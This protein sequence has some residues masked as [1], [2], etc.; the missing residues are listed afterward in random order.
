[1]VIQRSYRWFPIVFVF[2]CAGYGLQL[3]LMWIFP[4]E[5]WK[6]QQLGDSAFFHILQ[7]CIMPLQMF[8]YGY[9]LFAFVSVD[10]N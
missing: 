3:L 10:F 9:R 6:P 7:Y 2:L 8:R 1:M 5:E 4:S